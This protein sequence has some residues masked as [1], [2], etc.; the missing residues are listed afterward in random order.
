[1]ESKTQSDHF[2]APTPVELLKH[3]PA[4]VRESFARFAATR[5]PVAADE[6]VIAIVRDHVP[7]RKQGSTPPVLDDSMSLTA[8]LGIDSVSIADAVF[9]LEDVFAV[10]IANKEL[11][12]LRTIGD[13][14]AFIRTKLASQSG[15]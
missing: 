6:V 10:S 12:R 11:V 14:R 5:D 15:A 2:A 3:F 7:A 1:M 4:C 13:L 8:D 9:M